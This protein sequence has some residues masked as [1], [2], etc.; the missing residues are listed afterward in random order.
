MR[1]IIEEISL[2][3]DA[4]DLIRKEIYRVYSLLLISVSLDLSGTA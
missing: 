4:D 2:D 1:K 3:I